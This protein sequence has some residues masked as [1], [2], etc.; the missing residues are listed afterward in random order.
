GSS[1][2]RLDKQLQEEPMTLQNMLK[3]IFFEITK[4]LVP[5]ISNFYEKQKI[6][7]WLK[8]NI[9]IKFPHW[10]NEYNL[11]HGLLVTSNRLLHSEKKAIEFLCKPK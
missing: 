5:G 3:E 9:T 1:F 2:M 11:E 7:D 6:N 8:K 4:R 10:I